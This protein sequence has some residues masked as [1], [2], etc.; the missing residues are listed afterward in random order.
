MGG[1]GVVFSEFHANSLQ[2]MID[3]WFLQWLVHRSS[4]DGWS[5]ISS[6]NCLVVYEPIHHSPRAGVV[7]LYLYVDSLT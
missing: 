6:M 5:P 7:G 3:D 1:A 2:L 4:K